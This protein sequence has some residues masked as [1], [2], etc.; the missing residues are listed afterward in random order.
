MGVPP[1]PPPPA[2]GSGSDEA[3]FGETLVREG[4]L[5][6]EQVQTAVQAQ[7]TLRAQGVRLRLGE[8]L[9]QHQL[10]TAEQVRQFIAHLKTSPKAPGVAE[11]LVP[12]ERAFR[13][14]ERRLREGVEVEDRTWGQILDA[15]RRLGVE[16]S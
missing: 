3:R 8:I 5:S 2:A 9:V 13:E 7:Q 14:R 16:L 4:V 11:I 1:I 15:A 12:G 10:L 6:A